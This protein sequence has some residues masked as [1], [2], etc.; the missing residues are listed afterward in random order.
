LAGD[1]ICS[2]EGSSILYGRLLLRKRAIPFPIS[3]CPS[4]MSRIK[5]AVNIRKR[6]IDISQVFK[7]IIR[8]IECC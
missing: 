8:V 7:E 1:C 2:G 3:F 6:F 4:M 5:I